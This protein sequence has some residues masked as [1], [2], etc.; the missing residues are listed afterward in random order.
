MSSIRIQSVEEPFDTPTTVRSA[1]S[2]L[3][4]AETMGFLGAD[5]V[6]HLSIE[7]VRRVIDAMTEAGLGSEPGA[8]LHVPED[9][10]G[11]RDIADIL[12]ELEDILESSPAPEREWPILSDLFGIEALAELLGVSPA[13]VRRYQRGDRTT[14][15]PVA[16]RL[17]FLAMVVSDL[18]GA[19]NDFGIRRWFVRPRTVLDGAAPRAFLTGDWDPD[20]P[21]PRR[22]RALARALLGSPAT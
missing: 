12:A 3:S 22:V 17:H 21:G 2:F 10:I 16:A 6:D 14:P 19:Y 1:V 11:G 13:S 9:E 20:Q 4:R 7:A 15:D 5:D 8:L 18:S